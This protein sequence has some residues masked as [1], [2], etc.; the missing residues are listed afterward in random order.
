[1]HKF[2]KLRSIKTGSEYE[3]P[4]EAV[5]AFRV[6]ALVAERKLEPEGQDPEQIK[7]FMQGP[8]QALQNEVAAEFETDEDVRM[9]CTSIP[10]SFAA[11]FTRMVKFGA[12]QLDLVDDMEWLG[13]C[14]EPQPL[15]DLPE[16][17]HSGEVPIDFFLSM[18]DKNKSPLSM[19]VTMDDAGQKN[20]LMV[21]FRG[22]QEACEACEALIRQL[23][24]QIRQFPAGKPPRKVFPH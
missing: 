2:M 12:P 20:C 24:E 4:V 6:Q 18:L 7:A 3:L 16:G 23:A 10:W 19:A 13:G 14:D 9:Y 8:I 1:M 17:T 22:D 11:P 15:A 21:I 5:T